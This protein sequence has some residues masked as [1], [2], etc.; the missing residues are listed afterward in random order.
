M[1]LPLSYLKTAAT[2]NNLSYEL[3][4]EFNI[5][6]VSQYLP[7]GTTTYISQLELECTI[8]LW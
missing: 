2:A 7:P 6:Q 1:T 3:I 4:N 5:T 8:D